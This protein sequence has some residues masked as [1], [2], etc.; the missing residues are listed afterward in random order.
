MRNIHHLNV[1]QLGELVVIDIQ[2]NAFLHHMVRNIV[3]SL[4][5]VGAGVKPAGWVEELL[6]AKD[7][8]LASVTAPPN[9][10]YLVDVLYPESCGIPQQPAMPHFLNGLL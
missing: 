7:R 5:D 4:L 9:G 2:A 10:L 1:S 8:T 3:G 6:A